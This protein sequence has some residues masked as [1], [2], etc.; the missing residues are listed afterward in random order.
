[1]YC[2]RRR[3]GLSPMG[4]RCN[5]KGSQ[6]GPRAKRRS[7]PSCA[8]GTRVGGLHCQVL[9]PQLNQTRQLVVIT[10]YL[11]MAVEMLYSR[12][13]RWGARQGSARDALCSV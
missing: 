4:G 7:T 9:S 10:S 11:R 3:R 6:R 12:D 2:E 1:V 13:N 8:V 5:V